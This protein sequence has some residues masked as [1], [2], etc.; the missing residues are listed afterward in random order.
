MTKVWY[1]SSNTV[2]YYVFNCHCSEITITMTD[3]PSDKQ[4]SCISSKPLL[5]STA[6]KLEESDDNTETANEIKETY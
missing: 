1:S 2:V 6:T 3:A 4:C 5:I